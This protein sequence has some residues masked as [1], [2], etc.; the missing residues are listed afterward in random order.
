MLPCLYMLQQ[1]LTVVVHPTPT[2]GAP[3]PLTASLCCAAANDDRV[4]AGTGDAAVPG[5]L[6]CRG[7]VC[8][9]RRAWYVSTALLCQHE[10]AI[11]KGHPRLTCVPEQVAS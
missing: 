1:L 4:A 3:S 8:R 6:P 9:R 11:E 5:S 7:G 10:R 2:H